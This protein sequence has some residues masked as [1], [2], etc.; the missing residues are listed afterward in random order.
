MKL[1]ETLT[2]EPSSPE[3]LKALRTKIENMIQD[4]EKMLD[5]DG[6][7]K[8]IELLKAKKEAIDKALP[9]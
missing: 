8:A 3:E 5:I 6:A 7:A 9:I 2:S 1:P 4:L